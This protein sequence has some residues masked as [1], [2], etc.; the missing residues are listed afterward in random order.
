[1]LTINDSATVAAVTAAFD[2]YEAALLANNVTALQTF[3]WSDPRAV[4][5]GATEQLYGFDAIAEFRRHRVVNFRHRRPLRLSITTFDTIAASVMY[6]YVSDIG[7]RERHGRQSQW[8]ICCDGTWKIASAH[9]SLAPQPPDTRAQLEAGLAAV[10]LAPDSAWLPGIERN[11][12]TTA[13]L[14]AALLAFPLP[15]TTEPAPVFRP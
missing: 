4:R 1:M 5:F 6:E 14:A 12:A 15:E 3:F 10:G 11:F 13:S 2:A 9:I 7:G 8:W